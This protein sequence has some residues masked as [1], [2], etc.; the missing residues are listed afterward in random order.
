MQTIPGQG[1]H[2]AV[3]PDHGIAFA[4]WIFGEIFWYTFN[5]AMFKIC[6]LLLYVRVFPYRWLRTLAIFLGAT[7]I[8]WLVVIELVYLLQCKPIRAAWD[9]TIKDKKCLDSR[10]IYISQ[11][12]PTIAFDLIILSLPTILVW[13][14]QLP[15]MSKMMVLALFMLCGLVTVASIV[16]L[17]LIVHAVYED[18]TCTASRLVKLFVLISPYREFYYPWSLVRCRAMSRSCLRLPSHLWCSASC[19]ASEGVWWNDCLH[20]SYKESWAHL[21]TVYENE[22]HS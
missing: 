4:K 8:T 6:I 7:I 15:K 19:F 3:V 14:V 1:Q 13:R 11:S 20:D 22:L 9:V 5:L 10:S 16:R 2:A 17:D 18:F 21:E 12:V